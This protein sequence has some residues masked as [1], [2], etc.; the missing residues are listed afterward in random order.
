[1]GAAAA[2]L[3][4]QAA[5]PTSPKAAAQFVDTLGQRAVKLLGAYDEGHAAQHQAEFKSLVREGFDLDL[6]GRFVLGGA[7]RTA[8]EQQR[9]EYQKLFSDWV[10]DSYARRLGAY[11]GETFTITGSGPIA[12]TDALVETQI[13]QANGQP[14]NDSRLS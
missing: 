1:M 11:K 12:D 4:S 10:L 6:I 7:W 8:S 14:L 13:T 9:A 5:T 2:S 3:P